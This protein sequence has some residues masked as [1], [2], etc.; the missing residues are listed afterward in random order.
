LSASGSNEA[1]K[2]NLASLLLAGSFSLCDLLLR[3]NYSEADHPVFLVIVRYE[4][5]VHDFLRRSIMACLVQL[6]KIRFRN[7]FF[8]EVLSQ[9]VSADQHAE[10]EFCLNFLKGPRSSDDVDNLFPVEQ[11]GRGR[12]ITFLRSIR[13]IVTYC[14]RNNSAGTSNEAANR[15]AA[16]NK[17]RYGACMSLR[18]E[19]SVSGDSGVLRQVNCFMRRHN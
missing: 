11:P 5:F 17:L 13:R 18:P 4:N 12:R 8:T 14:R 1:L 19:P 6:I 7:T 15:L 9:R 3:S 10:S 16:T 2:N